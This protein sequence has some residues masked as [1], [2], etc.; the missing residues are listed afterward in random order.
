M[1]TASHLSL[2]KDRVFHKRFSVALLFLAISL[3]INY[4]ASIYATLRISNSVS[5][6]ILS[7]IP[8]YNVAGLFLFGPLIFWGILSI[9]M[10]LRPETIPFTLK[11]IAV[12][13]VI[14]SIFISL[15]HIGPF[16]DEVSLAAAGSKYSDL[17]SIH[18]NPNFFAFGSGGDLMQRVNRDTCQF[19]LKCC[20][21]E[22][23]PNE[24]VAVDKRPV[25]DPG[26]HSIP[27]RKSLP[28]EYLR[29][30]AGKLFGTVTFDGI[31]NRSRMTD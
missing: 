24:Y 1:E 6:I 10:I 8:V 11:S 12:F 20:A 23:G 4:Y 16:P 27:G 15:T 25:H 19:A 21:A 13:V 30:D 9:Y 18:I 29:F 3:V 5:D 28:P 26:K 14:R 31:R 22:F 7:N 17:L 2:W